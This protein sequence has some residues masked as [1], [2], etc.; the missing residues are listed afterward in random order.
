MV[1]DRR[2]AYPSFEVSLHCGC[3]RVFAPGRVEHES[4]NVLVAGAVA[5]HIGRQDRSKAARGHSGSPARRKPSHSA[6][7]TPGV[8]NSLFRSVS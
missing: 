2:Q 3:R 7:T 8:L 5:N 4:V 6:S 1:S